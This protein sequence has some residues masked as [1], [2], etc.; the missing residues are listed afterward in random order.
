MRI[1]D[2]GGKEGPESVSDR[3][4]TAA[5][6]LSFVRL[7]ALPFIYLDLVGGADTH[8]R[9]FVL[10]V[11]F[12]L[13]DWVDGYVARRFDQ[14][15]R[16]GKLLDPIAD[17]LLVIVV[18][19]GMVVSDLVPLWVVLVLLARDLVVLVGGIV[20]VRRGLTPPAV[21]RIGKTATFGLMFALP[22][23]I[24]ASVLGDG[25]RDPQP[26]VQAIAWVTL[27]VSTALYYLAAAQYARMVVRASRSEAAGEDVEKAIE[28]DVAPED[29]PEQDRPAG[30][31]PTVTRDGDV[32]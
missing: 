12:V 25:P 6:V 11:V 30:D 16:I 1:Y 8:L 15:T 14:V 22:S 21:T 5:N 19:F 27:L 7:L 4:F 18:G 10:L 26:V 3:V 23:F 24:L 20:L 29:V 2:I 31:G 17:R 13:T 32:R 9:A 28:A